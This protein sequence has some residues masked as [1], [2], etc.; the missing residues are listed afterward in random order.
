MRRKIP[1]LLFLC[2]STEVYK[3]HLHV[4]DNHR[5]R[6]IQTSTLWRIREEL[7]REITDRLVAAVLTLGDCLQNRPPF[8]ERTKRKSCPAK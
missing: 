6:M 8:T 5:G 4:E 3:D 7:G 2:V 1:A